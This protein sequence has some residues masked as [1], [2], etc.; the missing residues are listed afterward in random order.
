MRRLRN[1]L[2]LQTFVVI[3]S[4]QF[5]LLKSWSS[6]SL[7]NLPNIKLVK[8]IAR[9]IFPLYGIQWNQS[10]VQNTLDLSIKNTTGSQ[11]AVLYREVSLIQRQICTQ[12]YVAG[13][14]D[15]VLIREVSFIQSVFYRE[16]P[17]YSA[18]LIE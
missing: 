14:A 4:S 5:C 6:H 13:T 11:L 8:Y 9:Q 15:S 17:L 10:N 2:H 7:G 16:V 1:G 18:H 3:L 12:V